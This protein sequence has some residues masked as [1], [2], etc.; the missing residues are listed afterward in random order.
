MIYFLFLLFIT[1]FK[2]T[3]TKYKMPKYLD[4]IF[5]NILLK[6]SAFRL[7]FIFVIVLFFFY[8]LLTYYL[9]IKF[10]DNKKIKIFDFFLNDKSNKLVFF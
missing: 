8:F 6:A 1:Y 7:L 10:N 3:L 5:L 9:F 4:D 2:K